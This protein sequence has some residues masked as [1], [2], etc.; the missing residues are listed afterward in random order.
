MSCVFIHIRDTYDIYNIKYFGLLL[1]EKN[2][3]YQLIEYICSSSILFW[4]LVNFY[5]YSRDFNV[6]FMV[7]PSLEYSNAVTIFTL[8]HIKATYFQSENKKQK[9]DK[10][11]GIST[12]TTN[13]YTKTEGNLL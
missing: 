9:D 1:A 10:K 13:E 11:Y 5:F 8:E 6:Y 12:N 2:I 3:Q 7:N 4:K